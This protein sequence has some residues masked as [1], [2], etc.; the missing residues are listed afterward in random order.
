MAFGEPPPCVLRHDLAAAGLLVPVNEVDILATAAHDA[1]LI[2]AAEAQEEMRRSRDAARRR[3]L[4]AAPRD[5]V[6]ARINGG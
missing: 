1:L 5:A 2:V 4:V 3:P 6:T